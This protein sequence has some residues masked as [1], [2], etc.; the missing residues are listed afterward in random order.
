MPANSHPFA[1][2]S[3]AVSYTYDPLG[4][5]LTYSPTA[6]ADH[7]AYAWNATPDRT[8]ITVGSDPAQTVAYDAAHRPEADSSH[9]S[10]AAGRV[11]KTPGAGSSVLT[12][13][14]DPL[15]RL[16]KVMSGENTLAQYTYDPL[17]RLSVISVGPS[18]TTRFLYVGMSDVV[19]YVQLANTSGTTI[20]E[21]MTD[22]AGF[23]LA[24]Y[25]AASPDILA[26]MGSDAHGDVSWTT[27]L[28]GLVTNQVVFDPF[29]NVATGIPSSFTRWQGSWQDDATG[30]YYVVARWYDPISG[31]FLSEDP[32]D[33]DISTPQARNPYPY[34]VGDPVGN[35]DPD[36]R[37][38]HPY[39]CP[40][41]TSGPTT[42]DMLDT[43]FVRLFNEPANTA[44]VK[45]NTKLCGAGALAV[46]LAFAGNNSSW[47]ISRD[48][49]KATRYMLY[50][51]Y[52]V[53][54]PGQADPGVFGYFKNGEAT[55]FKTNIQAAAN[56]EYAGGSTAAAYYGSAQYSYSYPFRWAS[57]SV[58]LGTFALH[59]AA[60]ISQKKVPVLVSLHTASYYDRNMGLP[61]WK[62]NTCLSWD[63]SADTTPKKSDKS[64]WVC[65]RWHSYHDLGHYVSIV[66]YDSANFYYVDTCNSGCRSGPNTRYANGG[67]AGIWK[68]NKAWMHKLMQQWWDGGYLRYY[69]WP[70][71]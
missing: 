30:L 55:N 28:D 7:Q 25:D 3:D 71:G 38:A 37:C 14:Y 58:S 13:S 52:E 12:L 59:V 42:S 9:A 40:I 67:K 18:T 11:T 22:S 56:L 33:Q 29:G 44:T 49:A 53:Q 10:D 50:L 34:G 31:R 57:R 24:E 23:E 5:L 70:R 15:G 17:D 39:S 8:S 68:V 60:Q 35:V 62:Q 54:P 16:I 47:R 46:V 45:T 2:F 43:T 1:G 27:G 66:G 32:L 48:P 21:R 36:G 4:R 65:A 63:K 41:D 20:T 51:G 6:P 26:I 19:A 61:S 69:G 64:K